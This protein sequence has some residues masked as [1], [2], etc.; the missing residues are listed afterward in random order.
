MCSP[1]RVLL[2]CVLP[3]PEGWR[4]RV[5]PGSAGAFPLLLAT[6]PQ[7]DG[8]PSS[9][10]SLPTACYRMAQAAAVLRLALQSLRPRRRR[11]VLAL[12]AAPRLLPTPPLSLAPSTITRTH[13]T[14]TSCR[15]ST[16]ASTRSSPP[17]PSKAPRDDS[18]RSH[19]CPTVASLAALFAKPIERTTPPVGLAP[20]AELTRDALARLEAR[21]HPKEGPLATRKPTALFWRGVAARL[22]VRSGA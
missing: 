3:P 15:A 21:P 4:Q 6:A 22:G 13:L 11:R 18:L 12:Q 8:S 20:L 17:R 2:L 14:T 10:S 7:A 9:P 19:C 16:L 1:A 5:R